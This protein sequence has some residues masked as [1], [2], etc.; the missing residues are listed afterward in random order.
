MA[1]ID[2][3]KF[4]SGAI[5]DLVFRNL[6]GKQVVQSKPDGVKQ[7][8]LTKLSGNEF[9]NCSKW[10]KML[11][12]NLNDF[13]AQQTDGYMYRRFTGQL[14]KALQSNTTL[15]KGERTPLNCHLDAL[16]GFDFNIHSPFKD[17][18]SPEWSVT[19]NSKRQV[20]LTLPEFKPKKAV[21]FP[22]RNYNADILVYVIA[23]SLVYNSS[24]VE[25]YMLLPISSSDAV[26]GETNWISPILPENHLVL[27]AAKIMY[28]ETDK[29]TNKRYSNNK[30]LCPAA[31]V[32]A[33]HS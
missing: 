18:F 14:Y 16:V 20:V 12:Y 17:Y 13:L 9:R 25:A 30:A 5:G 2:K 33:K 1:R 15:M 29:F 8:R 19:L 6:D 24:I 28:Y 10:A 4:L 31:I 27:V 32:M 21:V 7:S 26:I 22:Q 23:T 3:N 11:R